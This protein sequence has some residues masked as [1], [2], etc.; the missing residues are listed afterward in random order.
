M[1]VVEGVRAGEEVVGRRALG[2]NL[3]STGFEQ[4]S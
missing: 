4:I 3:N 1:G 2:S